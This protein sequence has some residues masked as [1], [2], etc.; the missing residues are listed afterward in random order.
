[1]KNKLLQNTLVAAVAVASIGQALAD[2]GKI[3]THRD[4]AQTKAKVIHLA[5]QSLY[6]LAAMNA[7]D[8]RAT[9][10]GI[11]SLERD[12]WAAAFIRTG[13]TYMAKA[14]AEQDRSAAAKAYAAAQKLYYFGR[15]PAPLE[16]KQR[17]I[18]YAKERAAFMAGAKLSA[19]RVSEIQADY[20]GKPVYGL[21]GLPQNT[22]KAGAKYPL[23]LALGGLD[24]WK[25]ASFSQFSDLLDQGVAIL[26]ADIPGT[27][28]SPAKLQAGSEQSLI[29]LLDKALE[30]PQIDQNRIAV[31]GGS[32]GGYWSNIL[33]VKLKDRVKGVVSHS[34]PYAQTF[35][36]QQFSAVMNGDEYLYDAYPAMLELF[37]GIG[38][39]NEFFARF[40]QQSLKAQGYGK[41]ATAEMFVVGG[42]GDT[43]VPTS[44]LL[45]VL[46]MPGGI[47]EAWIN[48]TGI[49]MGRDRQRGLLDADI[50]NGI[51]VP[52][53]IKKLG[54]NPQ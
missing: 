51:V 22:Q 3:V 49:H 12:E 45:D 50:N 28:Q 40:A 35:D 34:G 25:E 31:Y 29:A 14:A 6:P 37:D 2:G 9:V 38:N 4:L 48:P 54:V 7:E 15:W 43:L 42:Q 44:D 26:T 18:A 21:L 30:N 11:Q 13:D 17:Q 20:H 5:E 27:G 1:M 52:W 46:A 24:H 16:S 8:V 36:R 19:H 47:K 53:L 10:A 39:E 41:Q 32:F 23:V 33:A